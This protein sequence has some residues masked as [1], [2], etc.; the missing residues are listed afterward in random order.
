MN[1]INLK[2]SSPCP[3]CNHLL[4]FHDAAFILYFN[5]KDTI[6]PKCNNNLNLWSIFLNTLD[7]C[8]FGMHYALLG[9]QSKMYKIAIKP[10]EYTTLDLRKDI[11]NGDLL[12][13]NLTVEGG[14]K[15][16]VPMYNINSQLYN[17]KL[18]VLYGAPLNE[19]SIESK[20]NVFYW[21]A[22]EE[23]KEDLANMLLLDAF[24]FYNERN[25][26]YMIISAHSA[27]EIMQYK[28]FEKLLNE[29][30]ISNGKT[31]E[32]LKGAATYSLQLD[33]LLPLMS[34]IMDFTMFDNKICENLKSLA[35][36]RNNLIHRGKTDIS[37]MTKLKEELISAFFAFKYFKIIHMIK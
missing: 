3:H 14:D 33:P 30:D 32:F 4:E 29:N 37:D 31:K 19:D 26:R 13:V 9:C 27:V 1:N 7:W 21:Y 15:A 17:D 18:T 25:Y 6:C 2:N 23:I 24:K 12:Y 11:G 10:N 28:F 35:K 22:P 36:D 5:S 20:A 8:D 16:I 34:K